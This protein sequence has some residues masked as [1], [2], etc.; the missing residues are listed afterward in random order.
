MTAA[1]YNAPLVHPG[2]V[3]EMGGAGCLDAAPPGPR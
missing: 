1:N 3:G 2:K